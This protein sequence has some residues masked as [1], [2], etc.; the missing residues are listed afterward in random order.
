MFGF[1]HRS[2]LTIHAIRINEAVAD[3]ACIGDIEDNDL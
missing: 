2:S 1:C 3:M